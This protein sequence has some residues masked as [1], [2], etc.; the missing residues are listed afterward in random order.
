MRVCVVMIH[1]RNQLT[2]LQSPECSSKGVD[3]NASIEPVSLRCSREKMVG[4]WSLGLSDV[5]YLIILAGT[6]V[7]RPAKVEFSQDTAERP[8]I[9]CLA[10]RQPQ[11]H[12][13]RPINTHRYLSVSCTVLLLLLSILLKPEVSSVMCRWRWRGQSGPGRHATMAASIWPAAG[14][15]QAAQ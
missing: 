11:Q 8:H 12:L 2:H 6:R 13:R 14:L 3:T 5:A 1:S 15:W 9:N 10:V 7:Q 4:N